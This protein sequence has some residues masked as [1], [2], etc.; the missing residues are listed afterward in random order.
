MTV[1]E[2]VKSKE[3][4]NHCPNC[5][6]TDPDIEWGDK[7]WLD[8]QA[9]QDA[10]CLK[11]GCKFR[12]FYT[13]SDTEF[14]GDLF[15]DAVEEPKSDLIK[16]ILA[17]AQEILNDFDQFGEVLQ[18]DADEGYGPDAPIEQLRKSLQDYKDN[19]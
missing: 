7:D 18:Q 3:C 9:F 4:F 11:C 13:Y 14:D 16:A 8:N 19:L 2:D 17:D 5:G 6:A 1:F 12:E 10:E 15:P